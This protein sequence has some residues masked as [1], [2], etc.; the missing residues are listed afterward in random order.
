MT[1]SASSRCCSPST[2]LS[3]EALLARRP[4]CRGSRAR[5][6]VASPPPSA[7]IALLP[8]RGEDA[9]SPSSLPVP[10]PAGSGGG[11]SSS[12]SG[13]PALSLAEPLRSL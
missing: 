8:R 3:A 5:R 1:P 12:G 2:E 10:Q 7:A 9:R 11:F 4:S 6:G 13:G